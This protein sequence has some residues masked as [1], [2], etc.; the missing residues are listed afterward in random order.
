[1]YIAVAADGKNLD[2]KVSDEFERC[3]YLLIVN[4]NDLSFTVIKNDNLSER[5]SAE[6][7]ASAVLSYNCE[8]LI[9]GDIRPL[10]FNILADAYVT[11]LFGADSSVKNALEL[12]E[13]GSLKIIKNY[14]GT[15]KC[16]GH[17]H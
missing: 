13:K 15:E 14:D 10:A 12:M 11:R 8:A 5:A 16:S 3:L 4:M 2:S 1:M 7:L 6:N 17:H 9:T